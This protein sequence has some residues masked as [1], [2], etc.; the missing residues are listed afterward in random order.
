MFLIFTH[1][2]VDT[3]VHNNN[4][5]EDVAQSSEFITNSFDI[6]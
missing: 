1:N 2:N 3:D 4:I 5:D 6:C